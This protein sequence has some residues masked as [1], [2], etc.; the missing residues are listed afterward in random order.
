MVVSDRHLFIRVDKTIAAYPFGDVSVRAA[1]VWQT[2]FPGGSTPWSIA[3]CGGDWLIIGDDNP[4]VM[5]A[6]DLRGP[7]SE[8]KVSEPIALSAF[9]AIAGEWLRGLAGSID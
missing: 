8:W 5:A 4:F 3:V 1:P 7:P 9:G 2:C 6:V